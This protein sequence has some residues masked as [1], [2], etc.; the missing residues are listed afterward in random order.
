VIENKLRDGKCG[1]C[2]VAIAGRWK[3]ESAAGAEI[4]KNGN[5][6]GRYDEINL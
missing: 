6:L 5:D 3:F 4:R 1:E 2:G